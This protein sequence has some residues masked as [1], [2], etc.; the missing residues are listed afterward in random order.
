MG[1]SDL[2]N[3]VVGLATIFFLWRQNEIF[4]KQNE[5]FASQSGASPM[6]LPNQAS[7]RLQRY[8]PMLAMAFLTLS[9]WTALG[10]D[11]Y[12]RTSRQSGALS[13][14]IP[15]TLVVI[16]VAVLYLSRK[17]IATTSIGEVGPLTILSA[18]WGI[19]GDAYKDVTG[20][21]RSHAKPGSVNLPASIG[22]LGDPY[23]HTVKR[24]IVEYSFAR[25]WSVDIKE[26]E[27][28]S[29]PE[30][31]GQEQARVEMDKLKARL[32]SITRGAGNPN[33]SYLEAQAFTQL[34]EEFAALSWVKKVAIKLLVFHGIADEITLRHVLSNLGLGP[35]AY[36]LTNLISDLRTCNLLE[37]K[38]D[39][40]ALKPNPAR[41]KDV[42]E[43]VADWNFEF[44]QSAL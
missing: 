33:R 15:W 17:R 23:P 12:T 22:L 37:Y 13:L 40:G 18:R 27:A 5:I 43:I 30:K 19:G 14:A 10:F 1:V 42:E 28:L 4:K 6:H 34:S 38:T 44:K 2:T 36:I 16:L 39:N 9:I 3:I 25:N 35:E 41:L 11:H 8:W 31:D 26:N 29:L 24:L 21:I 7:L 32:A 20:I